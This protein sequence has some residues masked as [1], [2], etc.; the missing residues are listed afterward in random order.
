MN[1]LVAERIDPRGAFGFYAAR[2]WPLLV[3][4]PSGK[5]PVTLHGVKDATSDPNVIAGWLRRWPEGNLAVA[6]GAPGPQ[7]LDIDNPEAVPADLRERLRSAPRVA[8]ARGWHL[9]FAG[10][11]E[12]T[13]AL[14]YGELRG[15]GSYVLV[16]PSIHPSGREYVWLLEPRGPLPPV[17][18]IVADKRQSAGRGAH[19]APALLIPHGQ[20]HPY[21][22]DLAVRLLRAGI[23]EHRR[24]AAHLRCEFELSCEAAPAPTSGYFDA[25]ADW[26]VRT[27]IAE[28]ERD[29]AQLAQMIAAR[30]ERL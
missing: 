15:R 17:P 25:L 24:I 5:E 27:H 3:C 30:R 28:R 9:Y 6:C 19:D 7:V 2:G 12:R 8:T 20:R 21:L 11:D 29:I 13:V 10:T 4:R 14:D 1:Q 22:T 18:R 26:A 23:T 16:P